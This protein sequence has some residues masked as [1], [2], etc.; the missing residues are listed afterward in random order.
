MIPLS[1]VAWGPTDALRRDSQFSDKW[2]EPNEIK[3]CLS[4]DKWLISGEKGTGKSAIRRALVEIYGDQYLVAPVVDFNDISFRV[5]YDHLVELANTTKLSKT[6]TLSNCWQ[7]AMIVELI[8]AAAQKE[9]ARY[10]GL[11]DRLP[12]DKTE[13]PMNLRLMKLLEDIWNKIDEFT[14]SRGNKSE[15]VP[16]KANLLASSGLTAGLLQHL[17]QF[18]LN[19]EFV[20]LKYKFFR[21]IEDS[22]DRVVLILDG[23][24]RLKNDKRDSRS[25]STKLIFASLV[26]AIQVIRTEPQLP[27][28]LEIKA[29]IPHDRYLSLPLRD[30]DK[31]DTMHVAIRWTRATLQ[32]FLKRRLDLVPKLQT[33]ANFQSAW[34]QVMPDS[35]V[36]SRYRLEEDSFD[37][38]ARHT[39][40]RPRQLQIHLEQLTVDYRDQNIDPSMVPAAVAASS[41][42]IAKFFI[43][44]FRTDYPNLARFIASMHGRDNVMEYNQ[45]RQLVSNGLH[46][47]HGVEEDSEVEDTI[48]ELYSMGLFGVLTF[49]ESGQESSGVYCPPTRE[50]RRHFVDF[51]FKNAHASISGT[52]QDDSLVALHPVF[53]EHCNLRP[54]GSLIVG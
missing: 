54:H 24:D 18:P 10:Q 53:I 28:S 41:K 14:G 13:V 31:I 46:R 51:F 20:E 16:G 6:T 27:Q 3:L 32:E 11:L 37:Y 19:R 50:S 17:S 1:S 38:L 35:V 49:I 4:K 23:F 12:G 7:Y 47:Y 39:M 22:G 33:R 21:K 2:V 44:E 43:D 45:F 40:L 15:R 36:N 8:V 48:D 42:S 9:P 5:L 52:L 30:S 29:F 25:D 34:Q 26:D